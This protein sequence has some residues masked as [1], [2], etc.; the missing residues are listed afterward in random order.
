MIASGRGGCREILPR[1]ES[2][3]GYKPSERSR[4]EGV[5]ERGENHISG[6]G[7]IRRT[8]IRRGR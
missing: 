8:F 6:L 2:S 1:S 3:E 5:P 7:E 4:A